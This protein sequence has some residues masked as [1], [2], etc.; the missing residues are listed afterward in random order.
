VA[1]RRLHERLAQHVVNVG[2]AQISMRFSC[3]IAD[4]APGIS[5]DHLLEQADKALYQAKAQ[6]RHRTVLAQ[7][8]RSAP[9]PAPQPPL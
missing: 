9:Q 7:R 5:V 8:L 2:S 3:G 6:G 1:L 4:W